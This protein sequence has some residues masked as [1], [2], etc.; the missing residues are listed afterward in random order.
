MALDPQIKEILKVISSFQI[1]L[2]KITPQ[3]Y[4]NLFKQAALSMMEKKI[5]VKNTKDLFIDSDGE[6]IR[7]RIYE[8][9]NGKEPYPITIYYHG[10]G[11]VLGDVDVYDNVCRM[12]ANLSNSLVVSVDYRL[13]PEYKFPTQVKDCY[14]ALK[15]IHE[16]ASKIKGDDSKIIVAG[17]SAGGNLASAVSI[18]AR[19]RNERNIK[20]QVLIY[21][22]V[23]MLDLSPSFVEF[24]ELYFLTL[25]QMLW[26]NKHYFNDPKDAMNPYASPIFAELKD[27]PPALIITAEYD[28][29]RDQAE[30]FA[31]ILRSKGNNVT[32]IRANGLIHG[33]INFFEFVESAKVMLAII[34]G[35]IRFI[36]G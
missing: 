7:L 26:F 34:A 21:P 30:T 25:E 18:F 15:W 4:R 33:F 35:F 32:C 9:L 16:N 10:G 11:F 27:L 13:A 22:V 36:S 5:E 29:L 12:L 14:N 2:N 3:E 28:P 19:D 31:K 17:D 23:N 1:D 6:K 20:A 24:S 8:P